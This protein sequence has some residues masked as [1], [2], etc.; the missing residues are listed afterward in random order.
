[1]KGEPNVLDEGVRAFR[2]ET[3]R[4]SDGRAT[5]ARVLAA[6]GQRQIAS[7][8]VRR[9]GLGVVAAILVVLSGAAAWTAVGRWRAAAGV[10]T[11]NA[12]KSDEVEPAVTARPRTRA[13]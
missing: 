11:S 1:M 7:R 9:F 4:A 3:A 10:S 13:K 6:A 12:G 2:G 5:R 8:D